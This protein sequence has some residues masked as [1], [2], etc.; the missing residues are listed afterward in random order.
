[1]KLQKFNIKSLFLVLFFLIL[2]IPNSNAMMIIDKVVAYIDDTAITLSELNEEYAK[3]HSKNQKITKRDTLDALINRILLIKEAKRIK[4]ESFSDDELINQYLELKIKSR[5]FIN[6]NEVTDFYN[7][8]I[9]RFRN[10][11]YLLIKEEIE[12]YLLEKQFNEILQK[13]LEGLRENS[14]I[15]ILIEDE[16]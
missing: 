6:E 9:E 16:L 3:L 10:Q 13:H 5:L 8:N 11:E 4:I 12:K 7:K 2:S 1:M 15:K 14:N